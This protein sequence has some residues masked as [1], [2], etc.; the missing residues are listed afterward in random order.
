MSIGGLYRISVSEKNEYWISNTVKAKI[1]NDILQ[2]KQ[3]DLER[4]RRWRDEKNF[5]IESQQK[6]KQ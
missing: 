1:A 4:S 2:E 3:H 5:Q 6:K